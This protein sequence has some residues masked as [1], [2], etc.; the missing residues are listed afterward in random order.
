VALDRER[1]HLGIDVRNPHHNRD[2][3]PVDIRVHQADARAL[4]VQGQREVGRNRRFADAAFAAGD[5]DDVLDARQGQFLRCSRWRHD[6][7][8]DS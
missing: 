1:R 4:L 3:R 6:A 2:A 5:R 8:L 7:I